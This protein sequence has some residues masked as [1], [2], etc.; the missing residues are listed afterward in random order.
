MP[1]LHEGHHLLAALVE[2]PV[3]VAGV[4]PVA[5]AHL[6]EVLVLEVERVEFLLLDVQPFLVVVHAQAELPRSVVHLLVAFDE[7]D[8]LLQFLYLPPVLLDL[9]HCRLVALLRVALLLLL[10]RCRLRG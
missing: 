3:G 8:L 10:A 5:F 9:L 7:Q 2:F 1:A 4:L 6:A